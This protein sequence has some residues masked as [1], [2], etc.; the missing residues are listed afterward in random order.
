MTHIG[1]I[2]WMDLWKEKMKNNWLHFSFVWTLSCSAGPVSRMSLCWLAALT[3]P[4]FIL[5]IYVALS[6]N[7]PSLSQ[8]GHG[9][10]VS[11]IANRCSSIFSVL[12]SQPLFFYVDAVPKFNLNQMPQ[13]FCF[14]LLIINKN[15]PLQCSLEWEHK[16]SKWTT[17]SSIF[18]AVRNSSVFW[19]KKISLHTS[20]GITAFSEVAQVKKRM[21]PLNLWIN[22]NFQVQVRHGWIV[23][24]FSVLR[25]SMEGN[26]S[27]NPNL[28]LNMDIIMQKVSNVSIH[29]MS[30]SIVAGRW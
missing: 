6:E 2:N 28:V 15:M 16:D 19:S 5:W 20:Q 1:R 18:P 3:A 30:L 29:K 7:Y 14:T 9:V 12:I 22:L 13:I 23:F 25:T 21:F 24:D 8:P 10:S 4:A 26:P 17:V 11:K 27:P